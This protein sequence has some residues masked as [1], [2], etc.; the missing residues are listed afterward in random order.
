[1]VMGEGHPGS[2]EEAYALG[3]WCADG[4]WWSSSIGLTNTEPQLVTRFGY[5]L[6]SMLG[7][8]RIRMRIYLVEGDPPDPRVLSIT[9]RVMVK[10]PYKMKK[11]AYQV[12]VNSRPLLRRFRELRDAVADIS[13]QLVGAYFGGRVDGD[14][15]LGVTPRIAYATLH[16]A[17]RDLA[18]LAAAGMVG[19]V[20]F[21]RKA[22]EYCIYLHKGTLQQFLDLIAPYNWKLQ[23][24]RAT[25]ERLLGKR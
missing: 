16:E 15:T 2:E 22:N 21:Y 5:Y 20:L 9:K 12:Y 6:E 10:P 13:P 23:S 3:L 4:Y 14:G 24:T 1:M 18:L 8:D 17:N 25:Y 11:T 19:S 7:S